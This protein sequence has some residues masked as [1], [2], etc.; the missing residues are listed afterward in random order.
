MNWPVFL[1]A[2][3]V[4]LCAVLV[5]QDLR[6]RRV[7]GG[8]VVEVKL[9]H[10]AT[11]VG[12]LVAAALGLHYAGAEDEPAPAKKKDPA[13]KPDAKDAAT[14]TAAPGP[15]GPPAAAKP[16]GGRPKPVGPTGAAKPPAPT[17]VGPPADATARGLE[18]LD[19]P[20]EAT[21]G[22]SAAPG[23]GGPQIDGGGP[24]AVPGDGAGVPTVLSET[25]TTE[26][27]APGVLDQLFK[28]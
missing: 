10:V 2:V 18:G 24:L 13:A 21:A 27:E 20:K 9:W 26:T 22:L 23:G 12:L 28:T 1:V 8:V 16:P 14:K 25:T 19:A 7:R 5:A 11:G 15:A 6:L 3:A 17:P 4:L